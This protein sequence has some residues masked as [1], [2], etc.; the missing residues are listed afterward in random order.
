MDALG[1]RPVELSDAPALARI[2]NHYVSATVVILQ[3]GPVSDADM[4]RRMDESRAASLPWVVAE[5]RGVVVGYAYA[6]KWKGRRAY[7]Y[8]VETTVHLDDSI[9]S[10]GIGSTLCRELLA[11]VRAI[12]M[13]VAIAGVALREKLGFTH[14]GRNRRTSSRSSRSARRASTRWSSC[15]GSPCTRSASTI[16]RRGRPPIFGKA[17]VGYVP[18]RLILGLSK[19]SPQ[20]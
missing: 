12:G 16:S 17:Q 3:E 14:V 5:L 11:L 18:D 9:G 10:R 8:S 15:A 2:Y 20:V 4:A 1:I 7:R 13:H 19:I 6:S